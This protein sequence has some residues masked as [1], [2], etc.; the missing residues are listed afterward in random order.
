ML[1]LVYHIPETTSYYLLKR[2]SQQRQNLLS[3]IKLTVPNIKVT[4][5]LLLNGS[6]EYILTLETNSKIMKNVQHFITET[7]RFQYK[8]IQSTIQ[9]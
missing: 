6:S 4:T 1:F 3:D 7:G 2:F 9:S 8:P 5:D